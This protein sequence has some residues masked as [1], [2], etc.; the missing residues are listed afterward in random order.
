MIREQ[1]KELAKRLGEFEYKVGEEELGRAISITLEK[2]NIKIVANY[3]AT[4]SYDL[5][6]WV[7]GKRV[8]LENKEIHLLRGHIIEMIGAIKTK[9][10]RGTMDDL[11]KALG[12]GLE[13]YRGSFRP[14]PRYIS[15][16]IGSESWDGERYSKT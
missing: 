14:A 2:N 10:L 13:K 12:S 4:V 15:H 3:P 9:D 6:L 8:A 5:Y 1:I 11:E 16:D 7:H